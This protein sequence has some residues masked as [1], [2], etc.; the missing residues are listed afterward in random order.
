MLVKLAYAMQRLKK[1]LKKICHDQQR[2][3]GGGASFRFCGRG[4]QSSW[5]PPSQ[6][7]K[8]KPGYGTSEA[9][10]VSCSSTLDKFSFLSELGKRTEIS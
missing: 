7:H 3:E 8:G 2:W 1:Y 5:G 6:S 10:K 4:T 9:T